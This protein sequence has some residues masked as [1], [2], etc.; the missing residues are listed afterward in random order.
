MI[1]YKQGD[2]IEAFE[3]GEINIIAHQTNCT[4]GMGAGIAKKITD[5]YPELNKLDKE[6][7]FHY[8]SKLQ[9]PDLLIGKYYILGNK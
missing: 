9:R 1:K 8:L 7:R 5:K 4:V 3:K 6:H 2:L